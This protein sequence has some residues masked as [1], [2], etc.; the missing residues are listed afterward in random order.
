MTAAHR[1]AARRERQAARVLGTTRTT[2]RP[3]FT[4]APDVAPLTLPSGERLSVEV[5]TRKRLPSLL[6]RALE[7]ARG[8]APG[9]TP[10]AVVSE[11]GGR[12]LVVLELGAFARIAGLEPSALSRPSGRPRRRAPRREQLS[13]P[14]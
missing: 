4:P 11:T 12:A 3:R 2:H 9:A 14:I 6:R 10:L 8:Y 13:L 1:R 5:K 7:Q